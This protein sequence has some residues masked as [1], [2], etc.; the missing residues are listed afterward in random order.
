MQTGSPLLM[1]D[2]LDAAAERMRAVFPIV[3]TYLGHV[4][5][6]PGVLWSLD[7]RLEALDPSEPRREPPPACASTRRTSTGRRSP[8]RRTSRST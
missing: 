2:E 5:S 6:Y 1:R 4:P 8:C 3:E 7:R